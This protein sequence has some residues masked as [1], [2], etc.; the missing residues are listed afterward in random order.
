ME[1]VILLKLWKVWKRITCPAKALRNGNVR[2]QNAASESH[3][4]DLQK[5]N[6]KPPI[7]DTTRSSYTSPSYVRILTRAG[8]DSSSVTVAEGTETEAA[9]MVRNKPFP[10]AYFFSQFSYTHS[11]KLKI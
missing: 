5:R 6:V 4:G 2:R 7:P 3:L 1:R 10:E 9:L 8:D 11:Q